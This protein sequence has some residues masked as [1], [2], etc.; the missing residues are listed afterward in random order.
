M[1]CFKNMYGGEMDIQEY[2]EKINLNNKLSDREKQLI[3]L[4]KEND[5]EEEFNSLVLKIIKREN[6]IHDHAEHKA[7]IKALRFCLLRRFVSAVK[8]A[9]CMECHFIHKCVHH[10]HVVVQHRLNEIIIHC[11]NAVARKPA[12]HHVPEHHSHFPV[13]ENQ[14]IIRFILP[15]PGKGFRVNHF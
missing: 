4:I 11:L 5:V 12:F 6:H 1:F 7:M 15:V 8:R 3:L 14:R 10:S 2:L 13:R 9:E